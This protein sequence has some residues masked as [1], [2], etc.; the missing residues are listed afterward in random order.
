MM[1]NSV[2]AN[3]G[4]ESPKEQPSPTGLWLPESPRWWARA[5]FCPKLSP[6]PC[7]GPWFPPPTS[8]AGN[9]GCGFGAGR[10]TRGQEAGGLERAEGVWSRRVSPAPP[11]QPSRCQAANRGDHR[12]QI[13]IEAQAEQGRVQDKRTSPPALPTSQRSEAKAASASK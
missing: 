12:T 1:R 6:L 4:H 8:W 11:A 13:H 5:Y 10:W 3:K 2:S 7:W 9:K